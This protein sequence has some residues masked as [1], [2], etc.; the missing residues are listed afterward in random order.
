MPTKR[1]R[2]KDHSKQ[3]FKMFHVKHACTIKF[4]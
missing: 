1:Q 2:S 4:N 3:H